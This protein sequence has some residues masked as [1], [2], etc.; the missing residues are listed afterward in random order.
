MNRDAVAAVR[1]D[2]RYIWSG[3]AHVEHFMGNSWKADRNPVAT[4]STFL[5]YV[6]RCMSYLYV[7]TSLDICKASMR[8][9]PSSVACLKF[10]QPTRSVQ[11][12]TVIALVSPPTL[13]RALEI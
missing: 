2:M 11:V 8:L 13:L 7:S 10:L 4:V 1:F 3:E 12:C 5:S 9:P 6:I